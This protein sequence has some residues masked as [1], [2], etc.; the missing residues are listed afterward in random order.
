MIPVSDRAVAVMNSS[1]IVQRIRCESWLDDT[2][3]AA[4]IPIINATERNDAGV[5]VPE[6]VTLTVPH[7]DGLTKYNPYFEDHPL[8]AYGQRLKIEVGLDI[9]HG[10]VEWIQRGWFLIQQSEPQGSVVNVTATGLLTLV[11]EA[12]FSSPYNPSGTFS[13]TVSSLIEPALTA[14][15]SNLTDRN[16]PNSMAW[17]E[18]R[19]AGLKELIDAWPAEMIVDPQGV[20]QVS[21]P[22]TVNEI[23][24]A[25]LTMAEGGTAIDISGSTTR[26][27]AYTHVVARGYDANG[28]IVQG[29][30]FDTTTG[31]LRYGGPFNSLGVPF[32]FFSPLLNTVG[33]CRKAARTV[34]RRLRR[35]A[36]RRF[37][38]EA[39]PNYALQISDAV[40]L[41]QSEDVPDGPH[42]CI[43]DVLNLPLHATGSMTMVVRVIA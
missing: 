4:D 10:D 34:L 15:F 28:A 9:G 6:R 30:A 39:V 37:S 14:E 29:V 24:V 23:P 31:A 17:D 13:A 41:P 8:A 43:I 20:L 38:V 16:V 35:N 18:D 11:H 12:R 40:L 22:D 26:D 25:T 5:M 19:L 2:L 3:L 32:F 27:G 21:D 42:T 1:H 33:E 36:A 7:H